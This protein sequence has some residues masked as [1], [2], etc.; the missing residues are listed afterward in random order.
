MSIRF[1]LYYLIV[2]GIMSSP[3]NIPRIALHAVLVRQ[4]W[5][6]WI[7]TGIVHHS[8]TMSPSS[9]P[10]GSLPIPLSE[11]PETSPVS[12]ATC[13]SDIPTEWFTRFS[14][15]DQMLRVV[16]YMRCLIDRSSRRRLF[17]LI[18]E[19]TEIDAAKHVI[20]LEAQNPVSDIS[21]RAAT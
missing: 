19:C 17:N 9:W 2:S 10:L 8:S 16:S 15:F 3:V 12:L 7:Y 5:S 21:Q 20:I 4:N 11:L 6:T 18:L 13:V 14:G 1:V